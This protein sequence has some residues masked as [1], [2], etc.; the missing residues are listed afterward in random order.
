[1]TPEQ[2]EGLR[3]YDTRVTGRKK[4]EA[5]RLSV[6][7]VQGF[8]P[9]SADPESAV[10]PLNDTP[11]EQYRCLSVCRIIPQLL[12][13]VK[14]RFWAFLAALYPSYETCIIIRSA[15]VS[16]QLSPATFCTVPTLL[17]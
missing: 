1:M 11:S 10:L 6:A 16:Q 3:Y 13:V 2:Y 15:L 17:R 8:E 4:G 7:G 12:R 14:R 9:R 5:V